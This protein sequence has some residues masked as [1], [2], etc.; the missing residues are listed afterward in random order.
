M[1]GRS[2]NLVVEHHASTF[3]N[4]HSGDVSLR[5]GNI[6][7]VLSHA[8]VGLKRLSHGAVISDGAGGSGAGWGGDFAKLA[9]RKLVNG[10]LAGSGGTWP[11]S[12]AGFAGI[13]FNTAHGQTDYGWM[14]LEWQPDG[15][16]VPDKLTMID[17][18]YDDSGATISAG[19]EGVPEPSSLTLVLL[20]AGSMGVLAWRKHRQQF[21]AA[22][23]A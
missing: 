5:R 11:K 9:N 7:S 1:A 8:G 13:R 23:E 3:F 19:N 17:W 14:R 2:F 6:D 22:A 21:T 4:T 12:Q 18:A 20:A 10:N 15:Y 16:G